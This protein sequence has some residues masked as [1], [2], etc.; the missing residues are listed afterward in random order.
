MGAH[1]PINNAIFTRLVEE[2][3]GELSA[4]KTPQATL[5]A[6]AYDDVKQGNAKGQ[7]KGYVEV[8]LLPSKDYRENILARLAD[9]VRRLIEG[10]ARQKDIA[11][12]VR[13]KSPV[14]YIAD[15]FVEEFGQSVRIAL[16]RLS[17][18]RLPR[19]QRD[20]ARLAATRPSRGQ[21]YTGGTGQGVSQRRATG[22]RSPAPPAR[23]HTG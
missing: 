8:A 5:L 22:G 16:M 6:R 17:V 3:V 13:S 14:Q 11:I 1:H 12:L 7:G 19:R 20:G 2:T 21:S 9:T 4:D 10:G 23:H 18:L 15:Y